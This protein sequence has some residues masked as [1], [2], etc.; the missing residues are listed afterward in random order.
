MRV[1]LLAAS[2]DALA[3]ELAGILTEEGVECAV[4]ELHAPSRALPAATF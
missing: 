4:L 3:Q 1:V 2:S